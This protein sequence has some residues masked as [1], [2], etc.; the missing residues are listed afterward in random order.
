MLSAVVLMSPGKDVMD[1]FATMLT[2]II[3][4]LAVGIAYMQWVTNERR[5]KSEYFD[6][7]IAAYDAI[8]TYLGHVLTNG[9]Q[10]DAEMSFFHGTRHVSFLFGDEI[11]S[12]IA[13]IFNR[14]SNLHTLEVMQGSQTG[15][16]L[17]DNLTKQDEIRGWFQ[18][19]HRGLQTKFKKY[20]AL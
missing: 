8:E 7:R 13:E 16:A 6:L 2:P 14:S 1:I 9:V 19:Q 11:A 15:V 12:L 20:L 3:A 10:K 4:L 18:K 5:R 17:E